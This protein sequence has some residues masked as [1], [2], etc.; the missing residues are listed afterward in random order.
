MG[1]EA[2]PRMWQTLDSLGTDGL[3]ARLNW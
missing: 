1:K 2:F 3:S